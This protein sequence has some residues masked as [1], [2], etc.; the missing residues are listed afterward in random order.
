M[1]GSLTCH[2][3]SVYEGVKYDCNKC[4]YRGNMESNLTCHKKITLWITCIVFENSTLCPVSGN[5]W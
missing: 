2:I 3:Q 1:H 5:N 4:E